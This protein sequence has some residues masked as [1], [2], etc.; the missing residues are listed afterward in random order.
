MLIFIVIHSSFYIRFVK[1]STILTETAERLEE[2]KE[3][4]KWTID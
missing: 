4:V 3:A 1:V 2:I